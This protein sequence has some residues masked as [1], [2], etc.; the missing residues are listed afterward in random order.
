MGCQILPVSQ[1]C[2]Q[3]CCQN[4]YTPPKHLNNMIAIIVLYN[5]TKIQG[6]QKRKRLGFCLISRQPSIGFLNCFFQKTEIHIK[7]LNI[8]QF[9]CDF[10]C[11]PIQPP[12]L[13]KRLT[14]WLLYL[15]KQNG[16]LD[17]MILIKTKIIW[18]RAPTNFEND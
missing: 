8:K 6:V 2:S 12:L 15:A 1:W 11:G 4:S 3:I 9:L 5:Q 16:I 14:S 18:F 17:L 13:I 10:S 7:I